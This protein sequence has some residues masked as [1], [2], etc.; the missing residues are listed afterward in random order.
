[1][2]DKIVLI[3]G[4]TRGIGAAISTRFLEQGALVIAVATTEQGCQKWLDAQKQAGFSK[5]DTHVCNV[6]DFDQCQKMVAAV[7]EKYQR[8]DILVNNAG[9]TRDV[10][11]KKMSKEDWDKVLRTDLD[12]VFNV[13]RPIV[14]IMLETGFGRIINIS[15]VNAQKGQFG[16]TNY[17]A[18][19]AGMYGFTKSLALETA[20]KNI[21]VNTVSPGYINTE[22]MADIPEEVMTKILAQ[23]P[24]ARLGE[25]DEV[26]RLVV[27]LADEKSGYITGADFS[28][29]GGLHMN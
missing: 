13:T 15:S 11:L 18:A 25:V 23:I 10:T 1:M 5:A 24:I 19:K 21:T 8:I 22:M 7:K 26:A 27:F 4:G 2:E 6:A 14:E 12:S 28:I 29:N 17:A 9:I 20:R 16:Q 3:T